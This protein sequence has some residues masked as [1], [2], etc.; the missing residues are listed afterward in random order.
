[1]KPTSEKSIPTTEEQLSAVRRNLC[2]TWVGLA[3]VGV[4]I[5]LQWVSG[6]TTADGK[7]AID[8]FAKFIA[9]GFFFYMYHKHHKKKHE[10]DAQNL[11]LQTAELHYKREMVGIPKIKTRVFTLNDGALGVET[12][13][14]MTNKSSKTFCIPAV[15]VWGCPL[16]GRI[17]GTKY[18][19]P[20]GDDE[21]IIPLTNEAFYANTV[22]QVGPDETEAF[23][24]TD[25]LDAEF[26][27]KNPVITVHV[28]VY[29]ASA[30]TIG[31]SYQQGKGKA[32]E[33]RQEWLKYVIAK[34]ALGNRP[35][36]VFK[37]CGPDSKAP[38]GTQDGQIFLV[39]EDG[40]PDENNTVKLRK[41]LDTVTAWGWQ[42][43]I[44]LGI[45]SSAIRKLE[46]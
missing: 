23:T 40:Q 9:A 8:L 33:M 5:V 15:Y 34:A 4:S 37:R 42:K 14:L 43:S 41:V 45:A 30:D 39:N 17:G 24:I 26:I 28:I 13:V 35:Y 44:D 25:I 31:M 2:W 19:D 38:K 32:G 18:E 6:L 22:V 10:L 16:R 20:Q 46:V 1:M 29:G 21:L 36:N 11:E 3:V 7:W 12:T 27:K